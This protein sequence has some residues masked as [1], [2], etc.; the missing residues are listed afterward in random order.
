MTLPATTDATAL[1]LLGHG[2]R[3]PLWRGP[4]ENLAARISQLSAQMTVRC[5]YLEWSS[6]DVVTAVEELIAQG[7]TSIRLL[8]LFFGMGKHAREDL[9]ELVH[10]LLARHPKLQ[11]QVLPSAGE[12]TQVIDL[13][14]EL[15]LQGK[16]PPTP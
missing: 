4:I 16:T 11:L 3:D 8:P 1:V 10:T 9:P 14:A 15:A 7:H 5:A 13:L 12:Q 2:S 6:P